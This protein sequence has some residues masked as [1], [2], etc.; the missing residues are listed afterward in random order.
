M[1]LQPA[2]SAGAERLVPLD[3]AIRAAVT[4][5]AAVPTDDDAGPPPRSIDDSEACFAAMQTV[6]AE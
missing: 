6:L 4:E 3:A 5:A 1:L 2:G